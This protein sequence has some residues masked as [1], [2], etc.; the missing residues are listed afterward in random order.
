MAKKLMSDSDAE[1]LRLWQDGKLGKLR[2]GPDPQ[3]A[4]QRLK[5][6]TQALVDQA[7]AF[8]RLVGR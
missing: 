2:P 6:A 8:G 7:E 3:E 5:R 1:T 4:L